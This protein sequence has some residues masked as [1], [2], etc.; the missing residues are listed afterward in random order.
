MCGLEGIRGDLTESW[1]WKLKTCTE[2]GKAGKAYWEN[3][4]AS[5]LHETWSNVGAV[6]RLPSLLRCSV[7]GAGGQWVDGPRSGPRV[8]WAFLMPK[9]RPA[10]RW[11]HTEGFRKPISFLQ[12]QRWEGNEFI[13]D[14]FIWDVMTV[15]IKFWQYCWTWSWKEWTERNTSRNLFRGLF[16]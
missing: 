13:T 16:N 11:T 9:G 7:R 10:A 1:Q 6:R 8:Y 14:N 15:K 12:N 4:S 3:G 2:D 5:L